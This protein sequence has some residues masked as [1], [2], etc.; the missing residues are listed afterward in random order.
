[1]AV[2]ELIDNSAFKWNMSNWFNGSGAELPRNNDRNR[3]EVEAL[4]KLKDMKVNFGE[5][6]A[7][8]RSTIQHLAHTTKTLLS[9]YSYAKR[10]KWGKVLNQLKIKPGRRWSTK[11]PAGRWLELQFG[12]TPLMSD[13][14]GLYDLSQSQLR[15]KAQL[16]SGERNLV[17]QYEAEELMPYD[18]TVSEAT[19]VLFYGTRGT[20]VKLYAKVRDSDIANATSL[21]LTDPLQVAWALVPFSFAIDW[22]LPVGSYLEALGAVKGLDFVSGTR[23]EFTNG[24]VVVTTGYLKSADGS[25]FGQTGHVATVAR[26][27]YTSFPFPLPYVKSPFSTSHMI[28]ALALFRTI[29]F[30]R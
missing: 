9:A 20:A 29:A 5:A 8:S 7:E 19:S 25:P 3:A 30:K 28:S 16:F 6:L 12:W 14:K 17:T 18:S 23:T 4:V 22:V 26:S 13:I 24:Q 15:E 27:T 1:M 11:D 10:G 21:G 2:G